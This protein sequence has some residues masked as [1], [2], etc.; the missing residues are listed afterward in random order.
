M[1][2]FT[3]MK[4][5]LSIAM[6]HAV[7]MVAFALV[8]FAPAYGYGLGD[9]SPASAY[10]SIDFSNASLWGKT[11]RYGLDDYGKEGS[12][13]FKYWWYFGE[14]GGNASIITNYETRTEAYDNFGTEYSPNHKPS[15]M[16]AGRDNFG[17]LDFICLEPLARVFS[18]LSATGGSEEL[19]IPAANGLFIETLAKFCPRVDYPDAVPDVDVNGKAKFMCWLSAPDNQPTNLIITAGRYAV[20][21]SLYRVNYIAENE[22]VAGKWYRLTARAIRNG[23]T[24]QGEARPM[25]A[26]YLDGEPVV[27]RADSYSIGED[28][29]AMDE[30]F[31]GNELYSRRALF[32]PICPFDGTLPKMTGMAVKGRGWLDEFAVVNSGDPFAHEAEHIDFVVALNP[33]AVTNVVCTITAE[34]AEEPYYTTNSTG[35]AEITFPVQ[36][37]DRVHVEPKVDAKYSLATDL[38]LSGNTKAYVPQLSKGYDVVMAEEFEDSSRLIA[39]INVGNACFRVGDTVYESITDAM[40]AANRTKEPLQLENDVTLDPNTK[41]GQM[42]VLPSYRNMVFD[43]HGQRIKGQNFQEEATIYNQGVLTVLDTVGGGVIEANGLAIETV[44]DNTALEVNYKSASL[45]LG[46]ETVRGDFTVTGRVVRTAGELVLKGGTYLTPFDLPDIEFY[47]GEYTADVVLGDARCRAVSLGDRLWRVEYDDRMLVRFEAEFGVPVPAATNVELS[48]GATLIEPAISNAVGYTVTNWYV[49]GSDPMVSWKFGEGG[50]EVTKSMTLVAQQQRDTYSITYDW[51]GITEPSSYT[52]ISKPTAL[53]VPERAH[54]T[55]AGWRDERTGHFVDRVGSG[56]RFVDAPETMV[57]GDLELHAQWSYVPIRWTNVNSGHSESNGT[58]AGSWSFRIPSGEGV[59]MGA[60]VSVDEI[61]FCIVNPLLYPKTAEY[62]AVTNAA[63]EILAISEARHYG[64]DYDTQEYLVGDD[65][66]ANRRA[67]VCY[68]FPGLKVKVG[69]L[70]YVCFSSDG[71][72]VVPI[73]AFLRL[74]YMPGGNDEVFGNCRE[75]G[76]DPESDA[77]LDFCPTYEVLGH[78][79]DDE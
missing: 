62:L 31:V 67:K 6:C 50:S 69:D 44:S 57:T 32:P 73:K 79:E 39:R 75:P 64:F 66:L 74:T 17:Y 29:A 30:L 15:Y 37:N 28:Q 55:F 11:P 1:L 16:A 51:P 63:G 13:E 60:T 76:G 77:Y 12:Q 9:V 7:G 78:L 23:S 25:F 14:A 10:S 68:R 27:C 54:F 42:H 45:V 22:V 58:Y 72:S 65:W 47:L 52:V 56:A 34:G 3:E 26:L 5:A 36:Y 43:L 21:G 2:Q 48:V 49:K 8:G 19:S 41:N 35:E 40:K 38:A 70:N 59:T 4:K 71:S 61:S 24:K 20:D 33:A 46:S 53:T 18:P